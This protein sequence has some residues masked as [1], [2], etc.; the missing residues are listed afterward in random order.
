MYETVW[1]A[2]L[3]SPYQSCSATLNHYARYAV[4]G[5]TYP[6]IRPATAQSVTGRVLLNLSPAA[7]T[8]LDEFEGDFYQRQTVHVDSDIAAGLVCQCYVVKADYYAQL[9]DTPW[10]VEAFEQH[11]LADFLQR[12]LD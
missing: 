2:L 10:S 6:G 9:C 1:H 7:F 11:Y 12:Y 4:C 8:I 5:E 3:K